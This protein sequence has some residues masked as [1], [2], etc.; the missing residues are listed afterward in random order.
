MTLYIAS[1]Y[2]YITYNRYSTFTQHNR[3]RGKETRCFSSQNSFLNPLNSNIFLWE[4]ICLQTPLKLCTSHT[5][6]PAMF[7]LLPHVAMYTFDLYAARMISSLS[8]I[9]G[10]PTPMTVMVVLKFQTFS[11]YNIHTSP[12]LLMKFCSDQENLLQQLNQELSRKKALI[13][14][15]D[16]Q[17]SK[18]VGQGIYITIKYNQHELLTSDIYTG[19][20]G[21]VYCGYLDSGGGRDMVAIKTCKGKKCQLHHSK[22][23]KVIL[24][25]F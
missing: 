16:L 3:I 5:C 6:S 4:Y 25:L 10:S 17:L 14:K 7:P 24:K 23:L 22:Q 2:S 1:T 8:N 19:E 20:S 13:S 11:L 9:C 21:L 12:S 15:K 18:V